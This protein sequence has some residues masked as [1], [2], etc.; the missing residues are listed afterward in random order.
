MNTMEQYT[1]SAVKIAN[2]SSKANRLWLSKEEH[3]STSAV[4]SES[5]G[6][7]NPEPGLEGNATTEQ[8]VTT[9]SHKYV[10]PMCEGI[11]SDQPGKCPKCGMALEL[12][13]P[14]LAETRTV[15]TCP[16]H[17]EVAQNEPGT[18]PK[19]GMELEP[20]FVT[21]LE[22]DD[23]TELRSMTQRFWVAVVLGIPVLLLAM[24]PMLD[25]ALEFSEFTDCTLGWLAV[26]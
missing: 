19:C 7:C 24:L 6:C 11:G 2:S 20:K 12:V 10:C 21:A 22:E 8:A 25:K 26:L 3:S 13:K 14:N 23:D 15:Y 1:I 9:K 5:H 17:P 16:M 4:V 18:C